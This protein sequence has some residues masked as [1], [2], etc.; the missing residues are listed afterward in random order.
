[1][2]RLAFT[3]NAVVVASGNMKSVAPWRKITIK[4]TAPRFRLNPLG[5]NAFESVAE[6]NQLGRLEAQ[7]RKAKLDPMLAGTDATKIRRLRNGRQSR[8]ADPESEPII[9]H[10]FLKH[11]IWNGGL[12]GQHTRIDDANCF[13]CGIP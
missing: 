1:Q 9:N 6:A 5:F 11:R 7:S 13:R 3:P 12:A 10:D 4:C 2:A 8:P